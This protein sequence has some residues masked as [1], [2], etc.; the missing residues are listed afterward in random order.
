[1]SEI[2][3]ADWGTTFESAVCELFGAEDV[4]SEGD[5]YRHVDAVTPD[6]EQLAIKVARYRIA[7]KSR[8]G[9]YWIPHAEIEACDRYAFGVYRRGGQVLEVCRCYAVDVVEHR[10]PAWVDSPR[11]DVDEVSRPPWSTF[12]PTELIEDD[13]T[14]DHNHQEESSA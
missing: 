14:P 7:E 1:M 8:R 11:D 12:V 10:L 9:R 5:E 3:N 13:D 4:S 2:A 6:G